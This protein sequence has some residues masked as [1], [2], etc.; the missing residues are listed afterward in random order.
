MTG[1]LNDLHSAAWPVLAIGLA[2]IAV[3]AVVAATRGRS[4]AVVDWLRRIALLA[5]VVQASIGLAMTMRGAAPAET[6]HWIYGVAVIAVVLL[7]A[8]LPADAPD[9]RRSWSVAAGSAVGAILV[10]RLWASG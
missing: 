8:T 9:S 6:L 10:W 2:S 4:L 5:L 1:A 7:P 3:V